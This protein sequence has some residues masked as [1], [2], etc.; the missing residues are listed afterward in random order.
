MAFT[1]LE[2]QL[3]VHR[4]TLRRNLQQA[5]RDTLFDERSFVRPKQLDDLALAEADA[6]EGFLREPNLALASIRG[7]QLCEKG[8]AVSA[9]LLIGQTLWQF[10]ETYLSGAV[11]LAEI[12]I[13]EVY[14]DA[15][16]KGFLRAW[17]ER[18]LCEQERIRA[19]LDKQLAQYADENLRHYQVELAYRQELERAYQ[20]LLRRDEQEQR[21]LARELHDGPV[22][23]LLVIARQ[24]RQIQPADTSRQPRRMRH[25]STP[26]LVEAQQ[27]VLEVVTQ[28]RKLIGELRPAGLEELGL[29]SA[30]RGYVAHLEHEGGL[31]VPTIELDMNNEEIILPKSV[32]I[33]LFRAAQEAVRNAVKHAQAQR[34]QL[35]L[36][37]L[38]NEVILC[39]HDDGCGFSPPIHLSSL[40]QVNCFGLLG[41][42]ERVQWVGGH[43]TL[44][45]QPGIGTELIIRIPLNRQGEELAI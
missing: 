4:V 38:L 33:C 21:Q 15:L 24:L 31:E 35:S 17:E 12:E 30:L 5:L 16:L 19:A 32:A 23:Q 45:S 3:A 41:M 43:F 13:V 8:L 44:N 28:L 11:P 22:Q 37:P 39:V 10:C 18:L 7:A 29:M 36:H 6:F 40:A 27:E 20:Q 25:P 9:V 34:I 42:A 1:E 14:R 2:K 26:V